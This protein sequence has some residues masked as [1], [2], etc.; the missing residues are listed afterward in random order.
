MEY[1]FNIGDRV[2]VIGGGSGVSIQHRG[3]EVEIVEKGVYSSCG[4]GYRVNPPIGNSLTGNYGGMIGESMFELVKK[5]EDFKIGDWVRAKG[6]MFP[7]FKIGKIVEIHSFY[8]KVDFIGE[9]RINVD[10]PDWPTMR[11]V[12]P[13]EIPKEEPVEQKT[14]IEELKEEANRRYPIG[15][16]YIGVRDNR[17]CESKHLAHSNV[18]GIYVGYDYVYFHHNKKWAE[19]ETKPEPRVES[20]LEEAK[21]RFPVGTKFKSP[22]DGKIC[23]CAGGYKEAYG[24]M[25]ILCTYKECPVV[26]QYLNL[27]GEWAEVVSSEY[28]ERLPKEVQFIKKK[29]GRRKLL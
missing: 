6:N 18:T 28:V 13:P 15:S 16:K 26:L 24:I 5:E 3:M 17:A 21:R 20:L 14:S 19:V 2:R 10:R 22:Y 1:K 4:N 29:K 11:R 9:G 7:N 27:R 25:G 23:T 8:Y 12:S